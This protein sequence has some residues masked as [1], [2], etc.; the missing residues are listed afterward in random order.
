MK[1]TQRQ[2]SR[3]IRESIQEGFFDRFFNK[4]KE[5]STSDPTFPLAGKTTFDPGEIKLFIEYYHIYE[6]K[7]ERPHKYQVPNDRYA[8][9]KIDIAGIKRETGKIVN[10]S[11]LSAIHNLMYENIP[12]ESE[13]V[14]LERFI[15]P[16]IDGEYNTNLDTQDFFKYHY[17]RGLRFVPLPLR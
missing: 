7:H 13:Q 2:L 16:L 15:I 10:P 9:V 8:V 6:S 17:P 4:D 1:I 12:V 5:E 3:L 11:I 14:L